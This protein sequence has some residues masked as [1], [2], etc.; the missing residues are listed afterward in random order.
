LEAQEIKAERPFR[1][2]KLTFLPYADILCTSIVQILVV[3]DRFIGA[4]LLCSELSS[5]RFRFGYAGFDT[6]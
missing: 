2:P 5:I 1:S 6:R 4:Q 3:F